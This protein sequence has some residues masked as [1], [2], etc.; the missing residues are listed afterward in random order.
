[1]TALN[2]H[3]ACKCHRPGSTE[4]D[5]TCFE[6]AECAGIGTVIEEMGQAGD[7]TIEEE[8]ECPRCD[9][10]GRLLRP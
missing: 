5:C 6:C 4:L 7:Q 1:M 8:T 2:H 9:G 3:P 10:I